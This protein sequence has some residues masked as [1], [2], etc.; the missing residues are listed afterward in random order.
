MMTRKN[1]SEEKKTEKTLEKKHIGTMQFSSPNVFHHHHYYHVR[2]N[3]Q[4]EGEREQKESTIYTDDYR[5]K[6]KK[7]PSIQI[8]V[9]DDFDD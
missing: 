9:N 8:M 7:L 4:W 1:L 3:Y 2:G 5:K 6:T